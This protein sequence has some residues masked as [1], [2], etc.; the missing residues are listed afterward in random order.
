M[1]KWLLVAMLVIVAAPASAGAFSDENCPDATCE[2]KR[3]TLTTRAASVQDP[4]AGVILSHTYDKNILHSYDL[5]ASTV[6]LEIKQTAMWFNNAN[7]VWRVF[8]SQDGTPIPNCEWRM[9]TTANIPVGNRLTTQHNSIYCNLPL[10]AGMEDPST[11]TLTRAVQS[12]T[13]DPIEHNVLTL[14]VVREDVVILSQ[15]TAFEIMTG[16][17]GAEFAAVMAVAIVGVILWSRSKDFIVQGFGALLVIVAGLLVLVTSMQ[18]GLGTVWD[19][20][21][22]LGGVLM[23][24][25][26]YML[27]RMAVEGFAE[28]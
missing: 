17:T 6:V 28:S 10:S 5:V 27:I 4:P 25:G 2:V 20:A 9:E 24:V 16:F 19:G 12:G 11:I 26:A 23:V 7:G 22:W 1:T 3:Y 13:P 18:E 15:K 8:A 21:V 14:I